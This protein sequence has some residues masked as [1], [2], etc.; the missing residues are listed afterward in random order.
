MQTLT[1]LA[2]GLEA[3]A[4]VLE[5]YQVDAAVLFTAA[6]IDSQPYRDADARVPVAKNARIWTECVRLTGNPCIGFEVGRALHGHG[7]AGPLP[8]QTSTPW[9]MRGWQAARWKNPCNAWPDIRVWSR[10]RPT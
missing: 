8:P 2:L 4:R 6:G 3:M 5:K 7:A 9:G 1:T 10:P